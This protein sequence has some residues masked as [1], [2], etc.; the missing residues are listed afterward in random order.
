MTVKNELTFGVISPP[1]IADYYRFAFNLQRL[2][3]G[4]GDY[5]KDF[6]NEMRKQPRACALSAVASAIDED[7]N[8]FRE[9]ITSTVISAED[10]IRTQFKV[11]DYRKDTGRIVRL[12]EY[13][14]TKLEEYR[15][16]ARETVDRATAIKEG[17]S[18]E[19][20]GIGQV[21]ALT[22]YACAAKILEYLSAY[23]GD[24][25]KARDWKRLFR[26]VLKLIPDDWRALLDLGTMDLNLGRPAWI[27]QHERALRYELENYIKDDEEEG[28]SENTGNNQTDN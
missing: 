11:N 1:K 26:G 4:V 8:P 20:L 15:R 28:E 10:V 6:L 18:K 27:E 9:T 7:F 5:Y 2:L 22:E 24:E 21:Y 17:E 23:L 12:Y 16:I 19:F 25:Q 14:Y 3:N 13:V